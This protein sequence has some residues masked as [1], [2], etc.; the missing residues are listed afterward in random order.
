[1]HESLKV[2]ANKPIDRDK[3]AM[4]KSFVPKLYMVLS[5]VKTARYL[6]IENKIR[7]ALL[8]ELAAA[9]P[10]VK[11]KNTGTLYKLFVEVTGYTSLGWDERS[12]V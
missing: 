8:Y 9:V 6:Q 1:M 12:Q 2:I 5:P 7:I 4:K 10:L 11:Q 3:A